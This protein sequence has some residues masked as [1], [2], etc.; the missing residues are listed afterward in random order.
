MESREAEQ[1][2]R[3]PSNTHNASCG[4]EEADKEVEHMSSRTLGK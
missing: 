3:S 1:L 4:R 2:T